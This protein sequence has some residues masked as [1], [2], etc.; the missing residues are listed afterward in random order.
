MASL[1]HQSLPPTDLGRAD[2][3]MASPGCRPLQPF[4]ICGILTNEFSPEVD[5]LG[6]LSK[7]TPNNR[8]Y[9]Q[10]KP[11]VGDTWDKSGNLTAR[12]EGHAFQMPTQ[13]PG[14]SRL[15]ISVS[16]KFQ[17]TPELSLLISGWSGKAI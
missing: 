10:G 11:S 13:Q 14:H 5:S 12:F 2:E 15:I 6:H 7:L 1:G 4:P 17:S 3:E 16:V 9:V 8:G